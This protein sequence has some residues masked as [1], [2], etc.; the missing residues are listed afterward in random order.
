MERSS[1]A[2]EGSRIRY[3]TLAKIELPSSEE[4]ANEDEEFMK[5]LDQQPPS[6]VLFLCFGSAGIFEPS[7]LIEMAIG[8]EQSG[9]R[10]LWSI[11]L[12]V[13]AET[14]KLEEI[15]PEGFLERTKNRGI[16]CG[17]APQV[18]ILAHKA[19]FAFIFH[20]G[21]NSTLESLWHGVPIV[22]CPIY[23]E[24]HINAFQLVR[25]I[26]VAVEMTLN[27]RMHHI[28]H[29]EILKAE[30]MEK[31]ITCIMDSENPTRKKV[32]D[33]GEIFRMALMEGGSSYISLGRFSETIL[34]YCN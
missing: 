27:Y 13:D 24:Q 16:V 28:D 14:T 29:R 3:I 12:P 8:L 21:W 1:S 5:W 4:L 23:A 10:F 26:E 25:D 32:K 31:A 6:S 7:Q 11:R 34:D 17:W 18:D 15:L 2:P 22:T 30:E 19:T 33:M 9:V 20:C